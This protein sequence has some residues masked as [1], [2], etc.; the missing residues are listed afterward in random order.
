MSGKAAKVSDKV[1]TFTVKTHSDAM[2]KS[3]K[4]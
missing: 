2:R 1:S 3:A 4:K